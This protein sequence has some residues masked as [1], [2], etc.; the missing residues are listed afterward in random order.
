MTDRSRDDDVDKP[1]FGLPGGDLLTEIW[2][3]P[4]DYPRIRSG[5]R[6][7]D[8]KSRAATLVVLVVAG[9]LFSAAYRH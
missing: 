3:H 7:R 1:R 5:V 4:L 6:K 8:K 9:L 2:N